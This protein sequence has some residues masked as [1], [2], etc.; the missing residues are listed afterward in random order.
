MEGEVM[1]SIDWAAVGAISTAVGAL[2]AGVGL[3]VLAYS[4]I[5]VGRS[6][7]ASVISQVYGELH[8]AHHTFIE[9]ATLRPYFFHGKH[10][11]EKDEDYM[12]ARSVAE[13]YLD[14]FEQIFIMRPYA[15]RKLRPFFDEYIRDM[16]SGSPFLLEYL[17]ENQK[18]LYPARLAKIV[19][20]ANTQ[21]DQI[22]LR[23]GVSAPNQGPKADA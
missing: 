7:R 16:L 4:V 11:G 10:I 13:M 20:Q 17:T 2:A 5:Q 3:L 14:I 1:I 12:Q 15:P 6:F 23:E 19:R 18:L 9:N 21:K 22:R 8:H